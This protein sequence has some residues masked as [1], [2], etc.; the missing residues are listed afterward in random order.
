MPKTTHENPNPQSAPALGSESFDTEHRDSPICPHCGHAEGDAWEID[1]GAGI[2]GDTTITCGECEMD[3]L[4]SRHCTVTYSTFPLPNTK[5][6][7]APSI[8]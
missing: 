3:Y 7:D 8:R 6:S 5:R 4:A 2:E 1:F